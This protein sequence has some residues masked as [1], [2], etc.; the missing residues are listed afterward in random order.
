MF[1]RIISTLGH[2]IAKYL[3]V[4]I[5]VAFLALA[6]SFHTSHAQ[7]S[8]LAAHRANNY[9]ANTGAIKAKLDTRL[10]NKIHETSGLLWWNNRVWTHNDSGGEPALYAVDT[11]TGK[12][13]KKVVV[14][15]ATN[16]DWEDLAQDDNYIY[17]GDFGNNA[18]GNRNDLKVYKVKKSDVK[19]KTKVEA[20]VIHFSY[21]DQTRLA[22]RGSDNTNFDCEAFIAYGDS[23]Y[24]FSKDWVDN[25]TRLYKLPKTSGTYTAV[26]IGE[27]NVHGL[28]TGATIIADK[29]VIVLTGYNPLMMPFIYLL[30]DFTGNRFFDGDK[31]KINIKQHFLQVEGICPITDTNFYISN[32]RFRKLINK[33]A[34]LQTINLASLLNPYYATLSSKTAPIARQT[35]THSFVKKG[36]PD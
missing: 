36:L 35:T 8:L 3:S 6:C 33:P 30:Y 12:V 9:K 31:R 15:N 28:I 22:A 4:K 19:S 32:E 23:L 25:K 17:I 24:L 14:T 16:V 18:H 26:N 1:L 21:N 10:S 5:C 11:A 7:P 34:M 13:V 20:T 2:S 27:L 29:R